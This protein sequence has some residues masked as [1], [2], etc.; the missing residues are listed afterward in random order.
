MTRLAAMLSERDLEA[1]A[2]K[3]GYLVFG[4]REYKEEVDKQLEL[5]PLMFG[6][7][8]ARRKGCDKYL[9]QMLHEGGLARSVEA[10]ITERVGRIMGSWI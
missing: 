2:E 1:H 7:F 4:S 6:E 3:T 5:V 8:K 10:T 9:G